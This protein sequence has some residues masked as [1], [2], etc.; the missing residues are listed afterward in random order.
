[1]SP[2]VPII[3]PSILAADFSKL[4]EDIASVTRAA[5]DD[6]AEWLH[7]DV[8]D[9]RFVPNITFGPMIV[10]SIRKL[11]NAFLDV[12]LMIEQPELI[13][14]DFVKAGADL[15]TV[16]CEATTHVHR[17]LQQIRELGVKCGVTLNPGTP[18]EAIR[19]C[20]GWVDL[21]LIMSVSPGFGGQPFIAE[22]VERVRTVDAWRKEGNHT[23]QIEV[24]GGVTDANAA[25]LVEAGCDVLV[26]GSYIFKAAD[27]AAAMRQLRA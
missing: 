17:T 27:R 9:G 23:F 15:I 4:G 5:G 14:A 7:L 21:V 20:L 10:S 19:P 6:A 16:H 18:L 1:M 13:V 3:S 2:R 12:H 26:A 11:S 24:D 25:A 22:A 8:M